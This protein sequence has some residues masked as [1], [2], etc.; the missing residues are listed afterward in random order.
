M[1]LVVTARNFG[2]IISGSITIKPFNVFVGP[3]NSGKSFMSAL[4]YS[5]M[6]PYSRAPRG[7]N[8]YWRLSPVLNKID[9]DVQEAIRVRLGTAKTT[10]RLI[11]GMPSEAIASVANAIEADLTSYARS[12]GQELERCLAGTLPELVRVTTRRQKSAMSISVRDTELRW[13]VQITCDG[14]EST[15]SV[16][17]MPSIGNVLRAMDK[18]AHDWFKE[19]MSRADQPD[20]AI[21]LERFGPVGSRS[22]TSLIDELSPELSRVSLQIMHTHLFQNLPTDRYYLPASR[23]G[24]MQSHKVLTSV[25]IGTA[26]LVGLRRMEIPPLS[27]IVGDFIGQLL[28]MESR[29]T[30]TKN[31]SRLAVELEREVLRGRV[32]ISVVKDEYPEIS[33]RSGPL[34]APFVRLSSMISELAPVV[35]YLRYVITRGSHM[36]I[37]EP[38]AHLH[39]QSQRAFGR[40]LTEVSSNGVAVTLTTHS[41]YMLT[42]I[43][44]VIRERFIASSTKHNGDERP[45]F[46]GDDVGAYLFARNENSSGTVVRSLVVTPSQGIPD[47]EFARVAEAMYQNATALQYKVIDVSSDLAS[48]DG[49]PS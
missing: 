1:P 15:Y 42:E 28:R 29:R 22:R 5:A 20:E 11:S 2:P 7:V 9:P 21:P 46:V 49:E 3:N 18:S 14:E 41:D 40:I 48:V 44:N 38:E 35:L 4:V 47:D 30:T 26:P 24:I 34:E 13:T 12:V 32:A 27:G 10:A 43:N 33:Y 19:V 25:Y 17:R 39:P 37:E 23:S 31:L 8:S 6:V 36:M 45:L 16:A